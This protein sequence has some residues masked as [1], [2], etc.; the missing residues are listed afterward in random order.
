MIYVLDSKVQASPETHV[1]VSAFSS[2]SSSF[3]IY[4]LFILFILN[5]FF[6]LIFFCHNHLLNSSACKQ[7]NSCMCLRIYMILDSWFNSFS[8]FAY[9]KWVRGIQNWVF[10]I[11]VNE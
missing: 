7:L 8:F 5:L 1:Y 6:I 2:S 4:F 10:S 3:F 11:T 9:N